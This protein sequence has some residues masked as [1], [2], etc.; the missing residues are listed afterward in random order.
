MDT[1][2]LPELPFQ[3]FVLLAAADLAMHATPRST[4]STS[5]SAAWPTRPT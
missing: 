2:D 1:H 4:R 3:R 5:A